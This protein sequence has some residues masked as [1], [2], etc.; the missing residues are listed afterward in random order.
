MNKHYKAAFEK[1]ST[2]KQ[3]RILDA[4]TAE[5]AA[6]GFPG[7]NINHIA[8]KA[9]ISIGA[10]YNYFGS[11]DDLF[12][13]IIDRAHAILESVI[14]E[15]AQAD[16]DI[17]DSIEK[18][19][20]AAQEYSQRYPELTQIYLDMTSEGLSHLSRQLS[21]QM[22]TISSRFY[23]ALIEK[24]AAAGQIH[25]GMDVRIASFCLDNLIMMIQYSYASDYFK[26]RMKI[27]IGP[28]AVADDEKLVQEIMRFIRGAFTG[29]SR[30]DGTD[31]T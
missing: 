16:A 18:L 11:K 26:E 2:E 12:L 9:G 10:M 24:A 13:T 4:G 14:S 7:A 31:G 5:F 30:P 6:K 19:L 8:K 1:I 28:E 17:F 20:R 21:G 25:R 27:F 23:R 15:V 22:E 3:A 29:G